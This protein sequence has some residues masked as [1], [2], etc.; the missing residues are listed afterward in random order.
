MLATEDKTRITEKITV[1]A[2]LDFSLFEKVYEISA[3]KVDQ[4][5]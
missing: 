4:F 1:N 3:L 2:V 5:G